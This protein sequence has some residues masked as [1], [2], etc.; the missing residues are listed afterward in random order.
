M[1][2][3]TENVVSDVLGQDH[4]HAIIKHV[5]DDTPHRHTNTHEIHAS[6][7]MSLLTCLLTCSR[8]Y[9]T[10]LYSFRAILSNTWL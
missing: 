4:L 3:A 9:T 1:K 6:R 8:S 5:K 7:P 10:F 2:S